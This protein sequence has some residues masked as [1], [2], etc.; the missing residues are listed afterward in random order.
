MPATCQS[1]FAFIPPQPPPPP[2]HALP[3]DEGNA[4]PAKKTHKP[5]RTK[6][7]KSGLK[8]FDFSQAIH[9]L[10]SSDPS[11]FPKRK[12]PISLE[13]PTGVKR[14]DRGTGLQ[15]P[16]SVVGKV[17]NIFL[18]EASRETLHPDAPLHARSRLRRPAFHIAQWNRQ[19][20]N[21][22]STTIQVAD[23]PASTAT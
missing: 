3:T 17:K 5:L 2:A 21:T 23:S 11:I 10:F 1:F 20:K 18:K 8:R 4:R 7:I 13:P 12:N 16:R 22:S 19:K 14:N 6:E 9:I 15:P